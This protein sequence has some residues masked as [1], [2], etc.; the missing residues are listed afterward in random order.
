MQ[1]RPNTQRT[2]HVLNTH[3]TH[4]IQLMHSREN[5]FRYSRKIANE[6]CVIHNITDAYSGKIF[7]EFRAI[8]CILEKLFSLE[9]SQLK[10]HSRKDYNARALRNGS[11]AR[12]GFIQVFHLKHFLLSS[13]FLH[14]FCSISL[15]SPISGLILLFSLLSPSFY[16]IFVYFLAFYPH[17]VS[18]DLNLFPLKCMYFL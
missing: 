13:L 2:K 11:R 14:T 5:C 4:N 16:I 12:C 10:S 3:N 1:H 18:F 15:L 7:I 9:K 6:F 17:F 8:A